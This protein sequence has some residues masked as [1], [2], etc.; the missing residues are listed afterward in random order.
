VLVVQGSVLDLNVTHAVAKPTPWGGFPKGTAGRCAIRILGANNDVLSR[1]PLD[2][3]LFDTDVA[4]VGGPMQV[5][6]CKVDD[7]RLPTLVNIP[8]LANARRYEFLRGDK[9]IGTTT[10]DRISLMLKDRR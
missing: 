3:S 7:P 10:H 2:L 9:L 8:L 1:I 6:C 5:R 4:R